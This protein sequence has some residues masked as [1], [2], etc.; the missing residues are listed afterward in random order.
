[1]KR[2]LSINEILSKKRRLFNFN[3]DWA[4]AFG[5]PERHGVWFIW[6]D[7]GNG[8]TDFAAKLCRELARFGRVVYNSLEEGASLPM[9]NALLRAGIGDVKKR[10][11]LLEGE[12]IEELEERMQRHKSPE[13]YIIDSFQ[14]TGMSFNDYRRFKEAH[15]NKLIIFISQA[16]NKKPDGAAARRVMFDASLKI[17]I[18]G[19]RAF[20]KGRSIGPKGYYTI[21]DE[22][23]ERYWGRENDNSSN[24]NNGYEQENNN[25]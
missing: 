3:E 11:G 12:S 20:S 24:N 10:F 8:K 4:A 17:Y 7:S 25:D 2:A 19:F 22:G 21:W 23:A 9:Q 16:K 13:F 6:G 1:M 5:A 15:P 18:E 14:Y